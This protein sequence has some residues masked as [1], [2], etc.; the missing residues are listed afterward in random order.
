MEAPPTARTG[1]IENKSAVEKESREALLLVGEGCVLAVPP[2]VQYSKHQ[3]V[4]EREA[5][6]ILKMANKTKANELM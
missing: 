4:E 5:K 2:S 6:E 1:N 3:R